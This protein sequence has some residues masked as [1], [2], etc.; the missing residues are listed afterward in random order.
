LFNKVVLGCG[1]LKWREKEKEKSNRTFFDTPTG[2]QSS[3]M[4]VAI[5]SQVV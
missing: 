2:E 1:W 3:M 4:M 5:V